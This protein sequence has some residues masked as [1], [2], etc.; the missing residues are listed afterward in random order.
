[1][2]NALFDVRTMIGDEERVNYLVNKFDDWFIHDHTSWESVDW[3]C[4]EW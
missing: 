3:L 4:N 2:K 1:M